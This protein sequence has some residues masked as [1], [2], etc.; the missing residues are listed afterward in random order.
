M[1]YGKDIPILRIGMLS[2][3]YL[4]LSVKYFMLLVREAIDALGEVLEQRSQEDPQQ[5]S[6]F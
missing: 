4:M 1:Y 6:N 2:V 3:K 5:F